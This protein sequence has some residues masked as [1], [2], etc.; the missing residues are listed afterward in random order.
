VLIIVT[1]FALF[2][3]LLVPMGFVVN[4]FFPKSDAD[5]LYINLE[6]PS[7]TTLERTDQQTR[8]IVE[9]IRSKHDVSYVSADIGR[10]YLASSMGAG[11]IGP[12]VSEITINLKQKNSTVIAEQLRREF[13]AYS[14]GTLS[15]IEQSSGPP[16]GADVQIKLL[17]DDLNQLDIYAGRVEEYLKKQPGVRNVERSI[18]PGTSKLVFV[19]DY[20]KLRDLGIDVQTVGGQ[21]RTAASGLKLD[22]LTVGE[23]ERDDEH[24][25]AHQKSSQYS[26]THE[27][28]YN[29][30][31]RH[32]RY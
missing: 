28:A 30:P 23:K 15:V 7:G 25:E 8:S 17:G 2:S 14:A 20:T 6:L 31:A 12:N 29:Y 21:L 5:A 1:L 3:Y 27:P 9:Q 26:P 13:A 11:G 19:P 4:E 10:T 32:W 18:K 24:Q 22:S 16:A